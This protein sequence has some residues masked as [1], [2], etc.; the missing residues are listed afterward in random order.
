MANLV[1]HLK[2]EFEFC[3]F[4][5]NTDYTET[6]PYEG[7][8]Y[9]KWTEAGKNVFIFYNDERKRSKG[10]RKKILQSKEF[11][12][13][14]INGI[15]SWTYS[16]LPIIL[17]NRN[18]NKPI[19]VSPR[20]MLARSAIGIK[21]IKKRTFLFIARILGLYK[22]VTFHA[23]NEQEIK[24]I[25]RVFGRMSKIHLA[26]NLPGKIQDSRIRNQKKKAPGKLKLVSVA[27]IAP[28]KNTLYAIERLTEEYNGQITFDLYGT[29]YNRSYFEKCKASSR[30]PV[31]GSRIN[32]KG[33][34]HPDEINN[35]LTEYDYLFMPSR[36]EN[37]GHIIL[38]AMAAA[39]PVIISDQTPWKDLEEKGVGWDI[40]LG[41]QMKFHEII[42][43]CVDMNHEEYDEMSNAAY[44]F[45]N[46]YISNPEIIEAAKQLFETGCKER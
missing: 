6:T 34:I 15:Y 3:I 12:L 22:N 5:R 36:G 35:N 20:G 42:Q 31:A 1:E 7:I 45:A 30:K 10:K 44:N 43:R 4:T 23:S 24:D 29:I 18:I 13:V 33:P 26:P 37:F 16:I 32:F 14:Y 27:R 41:N 8:V 21:S 39:L 28:E 38:E 40:A 9:D 19:I 2:D 46:E 11:D 17:I 25:K